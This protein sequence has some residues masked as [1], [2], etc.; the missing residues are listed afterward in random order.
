MHDYVLLI[1]EICFDVCLEGREI[2]IAEFTSSN[3]WIC[4]TAHVKYSMCASP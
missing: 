3:V 1:F 4:V 2:K